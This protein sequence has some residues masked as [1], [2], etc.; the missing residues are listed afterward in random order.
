MV[1]K[2]DMQAQADP[3]EEETGLQDLAAALALR[4]DAMLNSESD[5]K[6]SS[7]SSCSMTQTYDSDMFGKVDV[8]TKR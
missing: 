6:A 1:R 8:K 2:D 3:I 5:V 7:P 4:Q